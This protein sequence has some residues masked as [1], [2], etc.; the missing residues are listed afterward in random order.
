M[1]NNIVKPWMI[2]GAAT[3]IAFIAKFIGSA[4]AGIKIGKISI[5]GWLAV[6]FNLL[7]KLAIPL[8]IV[9]L[10]L[11]VAPMILKLL[12]FKKKDKESDSESASTSS[13]SNSTNITINGAPTSA[14]DTGRTRQLRSFDD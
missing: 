11:F 6:P 9:T 1:F 3:V 5:F 8:L 10:V 2:S 13:S 7:G 4:I 12:K 14:P